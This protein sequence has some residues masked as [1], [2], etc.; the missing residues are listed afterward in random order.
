MVSVDSVEVV[1]S[2]YNNPRALDLALHALQHQTLGGAFRLCVA[3]DGSGPDTAALVERWRERLGTRLRH[4]WQADHGFRKNRILNKAIASSQAEHLIFL[5]G[6]CLPSPRFV[7]RHL[8]LA[9]PRRFCTGGVIR[10][11][12]A[13]S[14]EITPASVESGQVFTPAWLAA[15][16]ALPGSGA[17]LKAGLYP[18]WASTLAE[19]LT[20]VSRTWNGGNS[21]TAR[22]NL[23]RVNGFDEN[24]GYGAEDIELGFR[25]NNAGIRGRHLRYTAPV[26]HLEHHRDYADQHKKDH[27]KAVALQAL[28]DGKTVTTQGI[29]EL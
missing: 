14:D 13:T 5:D 29:G 18:L 24:F 16:S 2:T 21:S 25:L 6:D 8:E 19:R 26:L 9:S 27:N 15:H 22:I 12:Q 20:T 11:S 10:L 17:R 23:I 28:K 1:V 3:D 7:A 4:I